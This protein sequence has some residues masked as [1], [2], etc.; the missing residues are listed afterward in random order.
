M[1]YIQVLGIRGLSQTLE[2]TAYTYASILT[3]YLIGTLSGALP[4]HGVGG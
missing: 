4:A 3:I 2:N 1:T